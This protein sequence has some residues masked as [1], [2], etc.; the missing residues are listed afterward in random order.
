MSSVHL[1][2]ISARELSPE[3]NDPTIRLF[4]LLDDVEES[5]MQ[6]HLPRSMLMVM[7]R[8]IEYH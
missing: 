1:G 5:S 8:T 7:I 2:V 3:L 6:P 4:P